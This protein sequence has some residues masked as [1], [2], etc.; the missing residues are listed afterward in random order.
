MS[1]S[2]LL[3]SNSNHSQHDGKMSECAAR[4]ETVIQQLQI[5]NLWDRC[6][7]LDAVNIKDT[8]VSEATISA[9]HTKNLLNR[10]RTEYQLTNSW[11]CSMCTFTNSL[12]ENACMICGSKKTRRLFY[13]TKRK[14]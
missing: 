6:S 4:L 8:S 1:K 13:H 2:V 5:N 11:N 7:H 9:I 12:N 14:K 3:V 10:L